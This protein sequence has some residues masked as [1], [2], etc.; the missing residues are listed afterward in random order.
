MSDVPNL[1]PET[2]QVPPV[3]TPPAEPPK[4]PTPP[5]DYEKKFAESTREN[6]LLLQRLAAEEKARQE[7]TKEPTDSEYR[8]AFPD[9]DIL[10]DAQKAD[11]RRI[12]N[13]ERAAL[14]ARQDIAE[15]KEERARNTSIQLVISST[16]ALQGKEQAF[17]EYASKPQYKGIPMEVL[18]DAFLG[19]QSA[20]P[21]PPKP[22]PKPG[23]ELGNGGP[24]TPETPKTLSTEA[25][26]TLRQSDPKAFQD[27]LKTHPIE[28]DI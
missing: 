12:Y 17:R 4:E 3:A 28:L 15:I 16:P 20:T 22:T 13:A 9:W 21:E 23:L 26:A 27:Y 8:T 25:L 10:D 24:R 1:P 14:A 2:D 6:Q 5:I 18:V 7:L 19:K 11:K